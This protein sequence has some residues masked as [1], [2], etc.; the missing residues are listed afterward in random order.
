MDNNNNE[1]INYG[2]LDLNKHILSDEPLL[3]GLASL[4]YH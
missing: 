2:E 1:T 4:A 3:Y